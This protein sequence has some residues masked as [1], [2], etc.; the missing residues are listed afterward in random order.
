MTLEAKIER[1]KM[2]KAMEFICRCIN[3]EE[4]F[5]DYWATCGVADGDIKF[6]DLTVEAEKVEEDEAYYYTNEDTF[7]ELM[8]LFLDC[9]ARARLDGGLCCG[10]VTSAAVE[11]K[12]REN[13]NEYW[14]AVKEKY[15]DAVFDF[16][17]HSGELHFYKNYADSINGNEVSSCWKNADGFF[18]FNDEF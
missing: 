5:W 9:M 13:I 17:Y 16:W 12:K 7:T 6:G 3:N 11:I 4:I 8:K 18:C 1:T 10:D 14:S 15:P 2:V